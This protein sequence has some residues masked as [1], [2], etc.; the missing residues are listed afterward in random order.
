MQTV[1]DHVVSL[2]PA[3]TSITQLLYLRLKVIGEEKGRKNV[4][5]NGTEGLL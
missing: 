1:S 5:A 3:D 2:A 4:R